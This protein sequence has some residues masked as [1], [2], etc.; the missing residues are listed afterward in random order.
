MEDTPN[1]TIGAR[2]KQAREDRKPLYT[3]EYVRDQLRD[4]YGETIGTSKLDK[5]ERGVSRPDATWTARLAD[6][7]QE[8]LRWIFGLTDVRDAPAVPAPATSAP[9][10]EEAAPNV[11]PPHR[12]GKR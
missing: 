2:L 3:R 4:R 1:T 8:D 10:P 11:A 6:L 7:Y 12:H 5:W 9:P